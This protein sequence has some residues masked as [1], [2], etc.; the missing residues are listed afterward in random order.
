MP[1]SARSA[2]STATPLPTQLVPLLGEAL[3]RTK[4]ILDKALSVSKKRNAL[5]EAEYE[6]DDDAGALEREVM[7]QGAQFILSL[8]IT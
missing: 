1:S 7:L 4:G 3:D 8:V 5:E 6:E 2:S